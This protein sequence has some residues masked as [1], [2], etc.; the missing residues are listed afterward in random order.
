MTKRIG[1]TDIVGGVLKSTYRRMAINFGGPMRSMNTRVL[2]APNFG[3]LPTPLG[4]GEPDLGVRILDGR[5][6]I[7]SQSLDVGAHGDPWSNVTPSEHFAFRLHSFDW[8]ADLAAVNFDKKR[9][10]KKPDLANKSSARAQY[11][12]DR[13]IQIYGKW[14]PYAWNNDILAN[15]VYAW[16]SNWRILLDGDK[17]TPQ[18]KARRINLLR[19]IIQLRR[20]YKRTH[21]GITKLKAASAL[22]MAG[23]AFSGRQDG[24][25][26]RGLDWLDDEIDLQIL[27]DGGHV[28]RS[29][30]AAVQA[31]EI[32]IQTETIL[33]SKGVVGS[34][35]IRRAIDRL[36]PMV[37]FFRTSDG[38]TFNFNGSGEGRAKY[39]DALLSKAKIKAKRFGFAPHTKYQRLDYNKTSI[40][41]DV[42]ETAPR[43][44]D[45]C[46]HLAPLAFEMSTG[47]GRLIV[48]CGWNQEQPSLWHDPMRGTAAHSTLVLAGQGLGNVLNMGFGERVLG[49]CIANDVGVVQCT[50]KEQELGTWLEAVHEG[51]KKKYGLAHRRRLYLDLTGTDIRGEDSLFVPLGEAPLGRSEILF[52]IR[53]HLHPSVKVT[54]AQNQ[55]SALLIQPGNKGW[56]FRTDAGP[57][58]IEKSV[59]LAKGNRP[60]RTEQLVITGAALA[61]GDG[62]TRS[63]R[64]RWSLKRMDDIE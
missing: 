37:A 4:L 10:R 26:E 30:L 34:K 51:Y 6:L 62:Q 57:L 54:L 29:P 8:F 38:G 59:Y 20:S 45:M 33:E 36:T 52:Q 56:R 27:S 9:L 31:L 25:L 24:L 2:R 22:V 55:Q 61:D 40:L 64:V 43:P 3:T 53:F 12:V 21:A 58:K 19:Q 1:F 39:Y 49:R 46:A 7:G 11:L 41:I 13:W 48:N 14:N 18:G 28:S 32:L 60:M 42:G 15:R 17:E 23:A 5:F 47:E 63:N 35:E 16:L 44:Y 50:R